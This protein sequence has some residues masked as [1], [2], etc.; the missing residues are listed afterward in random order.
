MML[1][2][3]NIRQEVI[4][5]IA[6]KMAVAA[7]TAPKARGI[8]NLEIKI[9]T[10][11]DEKKK[12]SDTMNALA[13]TSNQPFLE[14]DAKNVQNCDAILLIGTKISSTGLKNCGYCGLK[15][16][17]EKSNFPDVPCF[18]NINDLGIAI[19]SAVSIAADNRI[20]NRIMFSVGIAAKQLKLL[21][22][23]V[24]IILSIIL[25]ATSKNIFFDRH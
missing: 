22:D 6:K 24:K 2:E 10:H 12:L 23:D 21:H 25:S 9:I 11:D 5:E 4:L 13:V 16:C 8:D 19:G 18:V 7:R 15:N 1:D 3:K 20:D 14:R 17:T